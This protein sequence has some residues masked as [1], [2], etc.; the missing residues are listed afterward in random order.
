ML[1]DLSS[2]TVVKALA[3][4]LGLIFVYR[5][6][7][8]GCPVIANKPPACS[9]VFGRQVPAGEPTAKTFLALLAN[10]IDLRRNT[11]IS[12]SEEN[13]GPHQRCGQGQKKDN[14]D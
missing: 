14:E 12:Y 2:G 7:D 11:G 4:Q 9:Y 6:L 1:G 8:C 10:L 5:V 3:V 13:P